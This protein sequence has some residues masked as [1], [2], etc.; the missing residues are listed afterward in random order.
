MGDKEEL[1]LNI[2]SKDTSNSCFRLSIWI[3]PMKCFDYI[4]FIEDGFCL[5]STVSSFCSFLKEEI[6]K[7]SL[8]TLKG[9]VPYQHVKEYYD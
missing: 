1:G 4:D 5:F 3:S 9:R 8:P 7:M 2:E 6:E